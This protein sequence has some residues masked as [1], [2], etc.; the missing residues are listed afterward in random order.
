PK[1]AVPLA[2]RPLASFALGQLA[3]AGV[4]SVRVNLHHLG[5]AL[6][7]ALDPFIPE[8]TRV[9]YVDEPTLLGTGG[10]VR[11]AW[12]GQRPDG[13]V[14]VMNGD[15]HFAPELDR[16]LAAHEA[17]GAVATMILRPHPD[18]A[19]LGAIEIDREGRVRRIVGQPER[20]EGGP[21]DAYMFTGVHVL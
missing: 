7:P 4:R 9:R 3:R 11:N 15:I 17:S 19:S 8:G 1:P 5:A 6:P 16:A 18:P 12:E 10:G 21:L 2:H 14:I 13:P 20:A